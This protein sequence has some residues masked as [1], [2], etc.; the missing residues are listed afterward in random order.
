M[1]P[2]AYWNG[3]IALG[4]WS[5]W[6]LRTAQRRRA[7]MAHLKAC[8]PCFGWWPAIVSLALVVACVAWIVRLEMEM[9]VL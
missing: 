8:R 4:A 9:H 7:W 6:T 3:F 1:T 5:A 2:L